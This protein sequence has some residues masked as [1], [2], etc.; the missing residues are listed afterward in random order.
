MT[1]RGIQTKEASE[2][3]TAYNAAF[4]LPAISRTAITSAEYT[5]VART[6]LP[7]TGSDS[8]SHSY[9]ATLTHS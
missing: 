8:D 2:A 1:M 9:S 6:V 3:A 4:S 5:N 7:P